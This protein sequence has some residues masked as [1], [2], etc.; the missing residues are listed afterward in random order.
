MNVRPW[1]HSTNAIRSAPDGLDT[2]PFTGLTPY[3]R[4]S[5]SGL[6]QFSLV[7]PS[8]AAAPRSRNALRR[9]STTS[10]L[11]LGSKTR[12]HGWTSVNAV[13]SHRRTIGSP[14]M[15]PQTATSLL[16]L[17]SAGR[18][19]RRRW[20]FSH[21]GLRPLPAG[22]SE[23]VRDMGVPSTS[24]LA[25]KMSEQ[26][27]WIMEGSDAGLVRCDGIVFDAPRTLRRLDDQICEKM[28]RG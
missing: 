3:G 25:R 4:P 15:E 12:K 19:S 9:A 22:L 10:W 24:V 6:L 18:P 21:A 17:D 1:L 16:A 2:L 26:P 7:V 20:A 13:R 8:G 27:R 5:W 23:G 11:A 14:R 28:R